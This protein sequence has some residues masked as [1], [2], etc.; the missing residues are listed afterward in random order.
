FARKINDN[1]WLI[2]E[3]K[4]KVLEFF[5]QS[6]FRKKK[7]RVG[8]LPIINKA[9]QGRSVIGLLPTGGGKSLT[10]QLS[11][12]L[13]PGITLAVDPIRSLMKDQVDG[14][15]RNAID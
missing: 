12:F 10:Y 13:Q 15:Y 11:G 2:D 6:I 7:F 1:E 3:M 5:L 4:E 9:L 8:Q 14:L